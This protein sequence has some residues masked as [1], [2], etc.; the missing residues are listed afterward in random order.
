MEKASLWGTSPNVVKVIKSRRL[1]WTCHVRMECFQNFNGF[2][3]LLTL[4]ISGDIA[5]KS[6]SSAL[7]Q[8]FHHFPYNENL[9]RAL[10][11]T[12]LKCCLPSTDTIDR[13][14]KNSH[15]RMKVQGCL[16]QACFIEIHQVFAKKSS[17]IFP[18]FSTALL[19]IATVIP[20]NFTY[21][22]STILCYAQYIFWVH[23]D[24][25]FPI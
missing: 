7:L 11:T 22:K 18:I 16:M 9:T 14:E 17:N 6:E 12:S 10:N 24:M 5:E 25:Q 8:S 3:R 4:L 21:Y 2:A 20:P 23:E 15:M 1:R 13:W 19:K